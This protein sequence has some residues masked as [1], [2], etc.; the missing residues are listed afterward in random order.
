MK[1]RPFLLLISCLLFST[2]V[3]AGA[4]VE[5]VYE[6]TSSR[7]E[8]GIKDE[9]QKSLV[10]ENIAAFINE[11]FQ[12]SSPLYLVLGAQDGPLF[13]PESNKILIPYAFMEEIQSRFKRAK[14]GETG[15]SAEVA[16]LDALI[17][18]IF[19][20][21]AHALIWNYELPVLGKEEDAAD[22][23]AT[24][25]LIEY[26]DNGAEIAISAADLFDLE[27]EDND[28]LEEEDFWDEHSLDAQRFYSTMCVVYGSDP[29]QYGHLKKEL[30][31]SEERA[32]LCLEEY[33][34]ISRSWFELL[35]PYMKHE[36]QL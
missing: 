15:V 31:L 30:G 2:T 32:E 16:S 6:K 34:N 3:F 36:N 28:V 12:L 11:Q 1:L 5:A 21:L 33:E 8:E 25:L 20:E 10:V 23:L 26:F 13:D 29:E 24:V 7:Q 17:H 18:T 19:H 14:Y 9:L 27:S 22:N 35:E 4:G